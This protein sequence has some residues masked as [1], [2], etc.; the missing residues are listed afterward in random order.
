MPVQGR[1]IAFRTSD[2]TDY[3]GNVSQKSRSN[4]LAR[5][6]VGVNIKTGCLNSFADQIVRLSDNKAKWPGYSS[7]PRFDSF[8][9]Y[10]NI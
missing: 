2:R 5:K 7:D 6:A 8:D 9:F 10:L 4:W 3:L 1:L